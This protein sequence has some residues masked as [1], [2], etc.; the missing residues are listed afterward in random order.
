[1]KVPVGQ[2]ASIALIAALTGCSGGSDI[3]CEA[4]R[5]QTAPSPDGS[6]A[7]VKY[8]LDCGAISDDITQVSV[9]PKGSQ[10]PTVG[11]N[12]FALRRPGKTIEK[13]ARHTL[14]VRLEWESPTTLVIYRDP[15]MRIVHY[16]KQISVQIDPFHQQAVDVK[17]GNLT[18][19]DIAAHDEFP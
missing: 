1:M 11:G 9:L 7:A 8:F 13:T 4:K 14:Y 19:A 15:E 6:M 12:V 5:S 17:L 10:L 16:L 3:K 18:A 2:L